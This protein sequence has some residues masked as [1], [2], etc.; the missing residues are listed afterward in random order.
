MSLY[1]NYI[2]EACNVYNEDL[3]IN[4]YDNK[5]INLGSAEVSIINNIKKLYPKVLDIFKADKELSKMIYNEY[6][7]TYD[8]YPMSSIYVKN[9]Y[10]HGLDYQEDDNG[11]FKYFYGTIYYAS[12]DSY[13]A[14]V[15]AKY[16]ESKYGKCVSEKDY[17]LSVY[18]NFETFFKGKFNTIKSKIEALAPDFIEVYAEYP[19][20]S[21]IKYALSSKENID[22]NLCFKIKD[23]YAAKA[24]G[25][26]KSES[27]RFAKMVAKIKDKDKEAI[28]KVYNNVIDWI[29][30]PRQITGK[31]SYTFDD[32]YCA[33]K[34]DVVDTTVQQLT[35]ITV[36]NKNKFNVVPAKKFV[37]EEFDEEY[38]VKKLGN[39]IRLIEDYNSGSGDYIVL[40]KNKLYWINIEHNEISDINY[41]PFGSILDNYDPKIIKYIIENYKK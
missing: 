37:M 40:A 33:C 7:K 26:N 8:V 14:Q 13:V 34:N 31:M 12:F 19:D 10:A 5:Y 29:R 16:E 9:G 18:N 32:I 1:G 22:I 24:L 38:I 21:D 41:L 28:A 30:N 20:K 15:L 36:K 4:L 17:N 6:N 25:I 39:E 11:N 2:Q 23:D 35:N 27:D 3:D